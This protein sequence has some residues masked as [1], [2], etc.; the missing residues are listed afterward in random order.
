MSGIVLV[1][2]RYT[3]FLSTYLHTIYSKA[4]Q[5]LLVP[6]IGVTLGVFPVLILFSGQISLTTIP[7]NMLI[8]PLVPVFLLSSVLATLPWVGGWFYPPLGRMSEV[9]FQIAVRI[10]QSGRFFV[11]TS[12]RIRLLIFSL[13]I[14]FLYLVVSARK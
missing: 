8:V 2:H 1:S 7:L 14:I 6:T 11:V 10:D 13:S 9:L 3:E 12:P 4:L 5:F